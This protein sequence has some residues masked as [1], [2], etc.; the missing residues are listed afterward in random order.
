M[1]TEKQNST[2]RSLDNVVTGPYKFNLKDGT[3]L[4]LGEWTIAAERWA[5]AHFGGM[6][7]LYDSLLRAQGDDDKCIDAAIKVA[8]YKLDDD[9]RRVLDERRAEGESSE[10]FLAANLKYSDFA[11]LCRAIFSMIRDS[12][13]LDVLENLKK[14]LTET[15]KTQGKPTPKKKSR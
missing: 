5:K 4:T 6:K 11:V 14:N 13:P 12:M 1:Q 7:E 9:S 10:E 2:S 15:V 3:T 8:S